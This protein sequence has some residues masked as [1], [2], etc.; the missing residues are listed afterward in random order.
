MNR[1]E[2]A[3]QADLSELHSPE[4]E[5]DYR[6]NNY[7]AKFR[8]GIFFGINECMIAVDADYKIV[9]FN[10]GAQKLLGR[11]SSEMVGKRITEILKNNHREILEK[12]VQGERNYYQVDLDDVI[13]P[14]GQ[15]KII[16]AAINIIKDSKD[17]IENIVAIV[18]DITELMEGKNKAIQANLAKSRFMATISHEIRTPLAGILGYCEILNQQRVNDQQKESIDTI[19]YCA[20][21]LLGLVNNLLDLSRIEVGQIEINNKVFNL[22][23]MINK[24]VASVQPRIKEKKLDFSLEIRADIPENIKGD[25]L[26]IRQILSNLLVNAVKYT[27]E[28]KISLAVSRASVSSYEEASILPLQISVYDTGI[29]IQENQI[30]RLFEPFIQA[31]STAGGT[32]LGLSISKHLA[33]VMGGHL[34]YEPNQDGGSVFSFILSLQQVT[35][36]QIEESKINYKNSVL[37]NLRRTVLLV[38]DMKINRKLVKFMLQDIGYDV[39]TAANGQACIELLDTIRPDVILMDMQMPVMDGYAATAIIRQ[40]SEWNDIPVI[41]LTAYAMKSDIDKCLQAGCNYYLSK[42]FTQEQLHQVLE[43][44]LSPGTLFAGESRI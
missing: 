1:K 25:E 8:L 42:P 40:S 35:L 3:Y 12:M 2:N 30:E 27:D 10:D 36:E 23:N 44:S 22:R 43:A 15:V 29:G 28:G 33:E 31:D 13:L 17:K 19:Q 20:N 26:R 37:H 21:Q 34:W 41:A 11:K 32:G 5:F 9:F 14:D 4:K 7:D 39:L 24:T 6:Q 16:R 18:T 38:E